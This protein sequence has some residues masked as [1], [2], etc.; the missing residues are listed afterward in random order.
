[1]KLRRNSFFFSF[2][3]FLGLHPWHMEVPR[4]VVELELQRPAYT[5]A[6]AT[7]DPSHVCELHPRSRQCWILNPL[8]EARDWTCVLMHPSWVCYCWA[9]LGTPNVGEIDPLFI[10]EISWAGL[11]PL[12][13]YGSSC[14]ACVWFSVP[15]LWGNWWSCSCF[16][17]YQK[18][19]VGRCPRVWW[20]GGLV[21]WLTVTLS[22]LGVG[23]G[24]CPG[25]GTACGL[26]CSHDPCAVWAALL[27]S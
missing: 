8:S 4:L 7:Q 12:F 9:T 20:V 18:R 3:F 25:V 13:T 23:F 11:A 19:V 17:N 5:T 2:L 26:D 16:K 24:R 10:V 6:T 15:F 22:V 21:L 14:P 1:M 27:F